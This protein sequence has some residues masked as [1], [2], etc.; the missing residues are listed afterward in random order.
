VAEHALERRRFPGNKGMRYPPDP[1]TVEEIV[2]V[3]READEGRTAARLRALI[4]VL[5][6]A[7]LRIN[8]ALQLSETDLDPACGAIAVRFGKGGRRRDVGMDPR[9]WEQVRLLARPSRP[10]P[11]RPAGLRHSRSRCGPPLEQ[12]VRA[13]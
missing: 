4:V 3:M 2:A 12:L 5:W 9:G 10:A 1:P 13:R 7:G 6:R 11:C 8:E